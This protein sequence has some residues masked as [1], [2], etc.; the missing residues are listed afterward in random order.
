MHSLT[1]M[2]MAELLARYERGPM[3]EPEKK[4]LFE[5]NPAFQEM[6]ENPP[7]SVV[8]VR[9]E[10]QGKAACEGETDEVARFE[11]G[12]PADPTKNMS[13]EDKK[14]WWSEHDKHKDEFTGKEAGA[15]VAYFTVV[16]PPGVTK[17]QDPRKTLTRGAFNTEREA[18]AWAKKNIPNESYTVR[19][20]EDVLPIKA[21]AHQYILGIAPDGM[22]K[23]DGFVDEVLFA[24]IAAKILKLRPNQVVPKGRVAVVEG[25]PISWK[26]LLDKLYY[27]YAGEFEAVPA[28]RDFRVNVNVDS[29]YEKGMRASAFERERLTAGAT[30]EPLSG[31]PD[32]S[33]EVES[34][35]TAADGWGKVFDKLDS[36][37]PKWNPNKVMDWNKV[38]AAFRGNTNDPGA[39]AHWYS[40]FRAGRVTRDQAIKNLQGEGIRA[41][42][43]RLAAKHPGFVLFTAD[44]K[45]YSGYANMMAAEKAAQNLAKKTGDEVT[46][47]VKGTMD[48]VGYAQPD[49]KIDKVAA[50]GLYGYTKSTQRDVEASI[51]KA[52]KKA[53]SIARAIYSRDPDVVPFLQVHA[54]REGSK[55]AHL[56]LAAMKD[57][58][59]KVASEKI[60]GSGAANAKYL[61]GLSGQMK[62][63]ILQNVANHYGVSVPEI[64][65]ELK[66]RDAEAL[67]EYI[68]DNA[69]RMQV[70]RDFKT[71][72]LASE[73][74]AAEKDAA[75]GMYGMKA[76]TATLGLHACSELRSYVGQ[77]AYDL[78]NRRQARYD[79]ITGFLR[80]HA[81]TARCGY[82]RM[83]L[84]TYPDAPG[85]KVA[86]APG[87]VDAWLVWDE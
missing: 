82:A 86:S 6:N 13:E 55:S 69:L 9:E 35:K 12:K 8:K 48:V 10:M 75:Y 66:D 17:W 32:G 20:I 5:D 43:L 63:K 70:Y 3:T 18:H 44:G 77:V 68:T 26:E 74:V 61:D 19:E 37:F 46:I 24:M 50:G 87:S 71:L 22:P 29:I 64:E 23:V 15:K 81:K 76:K 79:T 80:E 38:Y 58:G 25:K 49:G 45:S 72:H 30:D 54:K 7:P 27:T 67:Y 78:H 73:K 36:V 83:L 14:K 1:A 42:A 53:A 65:A 4:Q 40:E 47:Q 85:S 60:A 59:P 52:Q 51:R 34:K 21:A 62:A 41:P 57:I 11:E 16:V 2:E 31:L 84:A 33:E 39:A 28:R 56:L